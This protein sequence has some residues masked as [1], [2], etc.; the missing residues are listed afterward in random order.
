MNTK[1]A[2][3]TFNSQAGKLN[4]IK[5]KV[6]NNPEKD[7]IRTRKVSFE[8][9][10]RSILSFGGGILTNELLKTRK[11]TPDAPSPA[12]FI[13]QGNKISPSAF[14]S[15]L[16]IVNTAFNQDLRYKGYRLVAAD[17]S[18]VQILQPSG[19]GFLRKIQK[20]WTSPPIMG[21]I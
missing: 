19:L 14:S 17:G 11:F 1:E 9:T 4:H 18:H 21:F 20:Q 10:V 7:F 2:I 5:S 12:A 15:L 8:F 13:Q 3:L 6:C 16:S